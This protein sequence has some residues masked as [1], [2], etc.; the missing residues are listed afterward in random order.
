MVLSNATVRSGPDPDSDKLGE[1]PQGAIIDVVQESTATTGIS[2]VQTITAPPG[3]TRGGWV[4]V[5]TSKG[6]RLLE[7]LSSDAGD[8]YS[9]QQGSRK[10]QLQVGS[11]GLQV[12]STSGS[13]QRSTILYADL[14]RWTGDETTDI[15]SI[16]RN[17]DKTLEFVILPP[18]MNLSLKVSKGMHDM[19]KMLAAAKKEENELRMEQALE[20][21]GDL[22]GITL[23][24]IQNSKL[25]TGVELDSEDCGVL[26]KGEIFQVLEAQRHEESGIMRVRCEGGW[27]SVK[28]RTGSR[29]L[30]THTDETAM[31][32][33]LGAVQ[34]QATAREYD[35]KLSGKGKVRI[36]LSNMGLLVY[37]KKSDVPTTHLY[38]NLGGW[39]ITTTGLDVKLDGGKELR[40]T[41]ASADA[42]AIAEGMKVNAKQLAKIQRAAQKTADADSATSAEP[43]TAAVPSETPSDTVIAK[44]GSKVMK[45]E[46]GG[47]GLVTFDMSGKK[48]ETYLY[49][50]L[51]SWK[52]SDN[53]FAINQNDGETLT[54]VTSEGPRI[55]D[56]MNASSK[57]IAVEMKKA[58]QAEKAARKAKE[59]PP[60]A[61][62]VESDAAATKEAA[63]AAAAEQAETVRVAAEEAE[64]ETA[65]VAAE[66][67]ESARLAVEEAE[68]ARVAAEEAATARVAAEETEAARMAAVETEAARVAVEEA[69]TARVAAVEAETARMAAVE[70]EAARVAAVETEAAQAAAADAEAARADAEATR[71]AAEEVEAARVVAE[72]AEAARVAAE[73]VETARVAAG[74]VEAA[75]VKAT[76]AEAEAKRVARRRPRKAADAEAA[77]VAAE[78]A[79]SAPV[80]AEEDKQEPAMAAALP[81]AA[82]IAEPLKA[83]VPFLKSA[84]AADRLVKRGDT[85][86][87]PEAIENYQ[88]ALTCIQQVLDD[89][90]KNAKA[91]GKLEEKKRMVQERLAALPVPE[92][93]PPTSPPAEQLPTSAP[94]EV[95]KPAD[96]EASQQVV[97]AV[98]QDAVPQ[99][100]TAVGEILPVQATHEET[101]DKAEAVVP[102]VPAVPEP[103]TGGIDP[104][105]AATLTE[106][107]Q[108]LS[109]PPRPPRSQR[110]YDGNDSDEKLAQTTAALE[111]AQKQ[112]G[113]L[114]AVADGN[115]AKAEADAARIAAT[116]EQQVAELQAQ[117]QQK[118]QVDTQAAQVAARAGDLEEQLQGL[119]AD[120][121]SE[122]DAQ[123]ALRTDLAAEVDAHAQVRTQLAA[124][125][126]QHAASRAQAAAGLDEHK[127]RVR[128]QLAAE[129]E[130]HAATRAQAAAALDEHEAS[131]AQMT[132]DLESSKAVTQRLQ[133]AL[134]AE[135]AARSARLDEA[136]SNGSVLESE[137]VAERTRNATLQSQVL[138]LEEET[139]VA[140]QE[141]A[142]VMAKVTAAE[143]SAAQ[144]TEDL[145]TAREQSKQMS[146]VYGS[147]E[148][149]LTAE[150]ERL[151]DNLRQA[152]AAA[153]AAAAT[154]AATATARQDGDQSAMQAL[155]A[156]VE[157]LRVGTAET[158]TSSSAKM[159]RLQERYD[160]LVDK[161]SSQ[162]GK[163]KK[164]L[165]AEEKA[166]AALEIDVSRMQAELQASRVDTDATWNDRMAALKADHDDRLAHKD[167]LHEATIQSVR[168]G[169]QT[170]LQT[171]NAE[172]ATLR[173][174]TME[175]SELLDF[176]NQRA[177][178]AAAATAESERSAARA[179][180]LAQSKLRESEDLVWRLRQ[181]GATE[182]LLQDTAMQA[183]LADLRRK[184]TQSEAAMRQSLDATP[185][186]QAD[187]IAATLATAISL[188]QG[189][190]GQD[191]MERLEATLASTRK[192]LTQARDTA[193]K[194]DA[195]HSEERTETKAQ[196]AELTRAARQDANAK[197]QAEQE[198]ESLRRELARREEELAQI[199]SQ[200]A[201]AQARLTAFKDGSGGLSMEMLVAQLE[202]S[203]KEAAEE[204]ATFAA[205]LCTAEAEA[206]DAVAKLTQLG[207][208]DSTLE[209]ALAGVEQLLQIK[210]EEMED[211]QSMHASEFAQR[212]AEH[213]SMRQRDKDIRMKLEDQLG[214]MASEAAMVQQRA[215][216]AGTVAEQQCAELQAELSTYQARAERADEVLAEMEA[217][218]RQL[219]RELAD[220]AQ[221][222]KSEVEA[223]AVS[224]TRVQELEKSLA[225]V[226]EHEK[227][228][229]REV[230]AKAASAQSLR[231]ELEMVQAEAEAEKQLFEWER[232]WR[233]H[234]ID[235]VT[236]QA[237]AEVA[238]SAALAGLRC[239]VAEGRAA[240]LAAAKVAASA[241]VSR[242]QLQLAEAQEA[243][244]IA[245][246]ARD[247][248]LVASQHRAAENENALVSMRLEVKA[249]QNEVRHGKEASRVSERRA[250]EAMATVAKAQEAA[251]QS[252]WEVTNARRLLSETDDQLS[253]ARGEIMSG[254]NVLS[255]TSSW[256]HEGVPPY[257]ESTS[258]GSPRVG[259]LSSKIRQ[260]NQLRTESIIT[261]EEFES[262]KQ[263]L[264]LELQP[265]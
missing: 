156:E 32:A 258:S 207:S 33:A 191:D 30:R 34:K 245:E 159:N 23:Q 184:L 151:T 228:L 24:V 215:G 135:E 158:E 128:T 146:E 180:S 22:T 226:Q 142:A 15:L 201:E 178:Q 132:A 204:R 5:K 58:K 89:P 173:Q 217:A 126:E 82:L 264:L 262:S 91:K 125:V 206:E 221:V 140:A 71:V 72:R 203:R 168:Q 163:V 210:E 87:I 148:K 112:L 233:K 48:L 39:D 12:M 189:M 263:A 194:E 205:M 59:T 78:Q 240:S 8:I 171:C 115:V 111:L 188:R 241:D 260:L 199:L 35:A 81:A 166:R 80:A 17:D 110:S 183:E 37:E 155:Q 218:Q 119:R 84:A 225:A 40:F 237:E 129:V 138:S 27:T 193:A 76:E 192:E 250:D 117:L 152:E 254:R 60:T 131:R 247:A 73:Q 41:C 144:L 107:P 55:I 150:R 141:L 234:E 100:T 2:V 185:E 21:V 11:M 229:A 106:Q 77:H 246:I 67:T 255:P 153:T 164:S 236:T 65:R 45:L 249:C 51:S 134:Q 238:E 231:Q 63:A 88:Q 92:K 69:E 222:I 162:V 209:A 195:A 109:K 103:N 149:T 19:C 118:T 143:R 127:A 182:S 52:T 4:K 28:S 16:T 187:A 96:E 130:Q 57:V 18:N 243:T 253:L 196:A 224:A 227:E 256:A 139:R 70:T 75:R 66:E 79:A 68:T 212:E 25:R 190:P 223:R 261:D 64:A 235:G 133:Q 252:E 251:A 56:A 170:E 200:L 46:A 239:E 169:Y 97:S 124:E 38:Q 175:Q 53:G 186:Q 202:E 167:T 44:L 198:A 104:A 74:E 94:E 230:D 98:P 161:S 114:K 137:L 147:T 47:M 248:A 157:R 136:A 108:Q 31:A 90:T 179:A 9:A 86:K 26:K 154:A 219:E 13:A 83:L 172:M 259:V 95:S 1:H 121:A 43:T 197:L 101:A 10:F 29:M 42:D 145:A 14:Q 20:A 177:D 160:A 36:Q 244:R 3:S 49:Q 257:T 93:Q 113:T 50:T 122:K 216:D 265:Y 105:L 213:M 123:T 181:A 214:V 220:S 61:D 174:S 176:A 54:F 232:E 62:T 208:K 102:A 165:K 242:L 6:R 99:D 7:R 116:F 120:L 211:V 85:T